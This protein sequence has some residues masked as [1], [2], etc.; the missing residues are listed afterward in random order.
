[1]SC[2]GNL[3]GKDHV[4]LNFKFTEF[5]IVW[6]TYYGIVHFK[7]HIASLY[8]CDLLFH[9]IHPKLQ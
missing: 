1:M 8:T 3:E 5:S 4:L 9:S 2:L 7:L 6:N